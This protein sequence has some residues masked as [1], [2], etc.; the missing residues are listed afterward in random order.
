MRLPIGDWLRS[1]VKPNSW[2]GRILK[3]T[4]GKSVTVRG[5]EIG[6]SE[7]QGVAKPGESRLDRNPSRPTPP[8]GTRR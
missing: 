1:I 2:L 6:L 7:G 3:L 8:F 4:K 5:V